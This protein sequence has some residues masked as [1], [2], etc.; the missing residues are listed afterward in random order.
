[1]SEVGRFFP[2]AITLETSARLP[3]ADRRR[4]DRNRLHL[5]LLGQL[6]GIIDLDAEVPDCALE[7]IASWQ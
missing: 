2:F 3:T 5:R 1:M 4:A 6:K 7:P